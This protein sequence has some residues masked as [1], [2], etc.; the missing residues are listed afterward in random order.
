MNLSLKNKLLILSLS[1]ALFVPI[2]GGTAYIL[3]N[4]VIEQYDK[5][6]LVTVP[7]AEHLGQMDSS[8]KNMLRFFWRM[9]LAKDGQEQAELVKK[10][11]TSLANFDLHKKAYE[12]VEFV[13]G[14]EELF[15]AV[16]KDWKTF[17]SL[18]AKLRET[19]PSEIMNQ[20]DAL[21]I[22]EK[23]DHFEHSLEKLH[24]FQMKVA[25]DR[26]DLTISIREKNSGIL[27]TITIVALIVAGT[28]GA[29]FASNLAKG[30]QAI[31][32]KL[33]EAGLQVSSSAKQIQGASLDLSQATTEQ[34]ASLEETAASLEEINSIIKKNSDTAKDSSNMSYS[35][36][37]KAI[38]GQEVIHK[39]VNAISEI[40]ESN[41]HIMS[42]V[43]A[44]NKRIEEIIDVIS[45][46]A[47]KTKV[48]NDIVFQ[49][50][51]LSFNASV[52]AA[53]A[54]EQGKG[55]AVVAEEVGNLAQ[56]SGN[57][58]KEISDMLGQSIEKVRSIVFE[59]KSSVKGL[60][61]QGHEKVKVG[62]EIAVECGHVLEE[63]VESVSVTT[64]MSD[65]ISNASSEQAQGVQEI[66]KAVHQL[67]EVTQKNTHTTQ[68]TASAA[69]HLSTQAESLKSIVEN[70]VITVDGR[71]T[72]KKAA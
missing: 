31:S 26:H 54:G 32:N 37:E 27:V 10:I 47:E 20:F 38:K 24:H 28:A 66:T 68:E 16:D 72:L 58:S 7:N 3:T 1:I 65:E 33:A 12:S 63:I 40:D 18:F 25:K 67:D 48:I 34:A 8:F 39:M 43:E 36:K 62:S 23:A 52:E 6:A 9:N 14:E 2:V 41:K 69:E 51:L 22:Q 21:G 30:L 17:L 59:T 11:D 45:D 29:F 44:S 64:R 35:S 55:F 60:V 70:L 49:T 56:M 4:K 5:I 42:E 57:A 46:I 61:E 50:K 71:N 19:P 15:N 53:R 13:E